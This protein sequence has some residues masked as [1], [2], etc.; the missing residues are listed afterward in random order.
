MSMNT[1]LERNRG[2]LGR[3]DAPGPVAGRIAEVLRDGKREHLLAGV[4]SQGVPFAPLARST[5]A[6]PRRRPG[7]PL[8]PGE[9]AA[10]LIVHYRVDVTIEPG[11]VT[12][13]AG[14]PFGFVRYLRSGTRK[15]PRR[16]PGGFRGQDRSGAMA[17]LKEF[18]FRG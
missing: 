10:D 15:M 6:D 17:T 3:V 18:L 12:C 11:R 5:V 4:D 1:L 8:V 7:G 13:S 14:W 16:D 9:A 2:I